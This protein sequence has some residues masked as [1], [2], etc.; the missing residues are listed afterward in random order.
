[1]PVLLSGDALTSLGSL[2]LSPDCFVLALGFSLSR[3]ALPSTGAGWKSYRSSCRFVSW[4]AR[5]RCLLRYI[6]DL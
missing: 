5:S 6:G 2:P 4:V 1:M 3:T